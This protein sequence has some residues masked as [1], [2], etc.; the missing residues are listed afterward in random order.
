MKLHEIKSFE[1]KITPPEE[2]EHLKEVK[3]SITLQV[4]HWS[5]KFK[6]AEQELAKTTPKEPHGWTTTGED[7]IED[8]VAKGFFPVYEPITM[9]R[10]RPRP[11][12]YYKILA[13]NKE[14]IAHMDKIQNRLVSLSRK[15]LAADD[16][17]RKCENRVKAWKR[18]QP[19]YVSRTTGKELLT[20]VKEK[21]EDWLATQPVKH[22]IVNS[23]YWA[24]NKMIVI[25][26]GIVPTPGEKPWETS[27]KLKV[28]FDKFISSLGYTSFRVTD[29]YNKY[30]RRSIVKLQ[31]DDVEAKN[32]ATT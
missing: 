29:F 9:G 16:E 24:K 19:D 2:L 5:E 27:A 14:Q 3:Q 1:E 10:E 17:I 30:D 7:K 8:R 31:L 23:Y 6:E 13:T 4:N 18:K 25:E 21:V 28:A 12:G 32:K 26:I 11:S 15:Q 22:S 20:S